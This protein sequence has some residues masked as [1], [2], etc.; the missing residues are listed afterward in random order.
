MFEVFNEIGIIEQLARN[1]FERVLPHGMTLSQFSVLNH[2]ARLGGEKSPLALARAFQ[3]SKGTMT[4][5]LQ[6]LEVQGLVVL[7]PDPT[8]GRGKLVAITPLGESRREEA[9]AAR[10]DATAAL[11]HA[12]NWIGAVTWLSRLGALAYAGMTVTAV[13][14]RRS[15]TCALSVKS[16]GSWRKTQSASIAAL[17]SSM[18]SEKTRTPLRARRS[19]IA[20]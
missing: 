14:A 2:F 11:T 4:N 13:F 16:G 7:R 8:D 6:R 17:A 1:R 5:T 3:V 15:L 18:Q 9:V 10:H 20:I 12:Y 19:D